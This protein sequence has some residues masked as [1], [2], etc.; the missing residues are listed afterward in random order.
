MQSFSYLLVVRMLCYFSVWGPQDLI[1]VEIC[2]KFE[3]WSLMFPASFR[4]N[5][6]PMLLTLLNHLLL[7]FPRHFFVMT[8]ILLMNPATSR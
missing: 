4:R 7:G 1:E 5:L 8:E 6:L 3:V 2:L